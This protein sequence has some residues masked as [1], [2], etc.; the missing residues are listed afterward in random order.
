VTSITQDYATSITAPADPT[1]EGYLFIGWYN[2]L[3][4]TTKFIFDTMPADDLLLYARWETNPKISPENLVEGNLFGEVLATS[5]DYYAVSAIYSENGL[6]KVYIFQ[7]GYSEIV[8]TIELEN[9][10]LNDRFGYSISMV[11]DYIVV[12]VPF[13]D[14]DGIRNTGAVMVYKLSDPSYLRIITHPTP[15][16]D[17]WFGYYVFAHD[18]YLITTAIFDD[19]GDFNTGSIFIYRFSDDNYIRKIQPNIQNTG[20]RLGETI[21]AYGDYIFVNDP[22][23]SSRGGGIYVFKFSDENYE[24]ILE[25]PDSSSSDFFGD[26]IVANDQYLIISTWGDDFDEYLDAGTVYI[27][28]MSDFTLIETLRA[29]TPVTGALF[30]SSLA[31]Y[32]NVLVIGARSNKVDGLQKGVVYFYDLSTSLF[33]QTIIAPDGDFN[34][35]FGESVIFNGTYLIVGAPYDDDVAENSGAIY[36]FDLS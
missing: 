1:K 9:G 3:S 22:K 36:V 25:N 6:G 12:G 7:Y 5:G 17:D 31:I 14:V 27:Y 20:A 10:V 32:N 13:L 34:D 11:G 33:I 28:Q 29:E 15:S 30:G 2:D 16:M 4:F 8:R 24:M 26:V 18:D 21:Y 19:D 23:L 35:R